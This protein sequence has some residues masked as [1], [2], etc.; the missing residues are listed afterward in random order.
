MGC[1]LID[2]IQVVLILHQPEGIKYLADDLV[3]VFR[4]LRQ[5]RVLEQL[6]LRGPLF[7][8]RLCRLKLADLAAH[9]NN[10]AVALRCREVRE[11][12]RRMEELARS[13]CYTVSGLAVTGSDLIAA[14][15][16]PGPLVGTTLEWLLQR[17]MRGDLP[18]E[19]EALLLA[20]RTR[21][22]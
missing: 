8:Q 18:N 10:D 9:T 15:L 12:S 22:N 2:D 11:F 6:H 3:P 16:T 5:K 4:L 13:G 17:V 21:Q 7:L 20:V 1:M 14:G 19:R